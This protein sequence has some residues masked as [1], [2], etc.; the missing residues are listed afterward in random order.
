MTEKIS[1][2]VPVYNV[3]TYLRQCLDSIL[4]QTYQNLEILVIND[5]STDGSDAICREYEAKDE[6]LRYFTKGNSSLLNMRNFGIQQASGDY[7]TFVNPADW[8]ERN[9][10]E[11]LYTSLKAHDADISIANYSLF[12][13]SEKIFYFFIGETDY[14]ERLY[15]PYQ[16]LDELYETRFNKHIALTSAWG[17]LYKRSIL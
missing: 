3:E 11:E 13:E 17:K 5:G 9:Y 15:L 6:R 1:V 4:R 7:I 14:Y 2:I 12:K 8:L 10:L 16:V